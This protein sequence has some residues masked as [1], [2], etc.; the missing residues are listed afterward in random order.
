MLKPS[1]N[2]ILSQILTSVQLT[3]IIV[4][5][6]LIV[7]ILWGPLIAHATLDTQETEQHALVNVITLFSI[8]VPFLSHL[9][10]R[11]QRIN[12]FRFNRNNQI[13]AKKGEHFHPTVLVTM[14]YLV[15]ADFIST[16][17]PRNL[18][19]YTFKICIINKFNGITENQL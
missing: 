12:C 4:M 15:T 7:T 18:R 9:Q 19:E 5:S 6:M 16:K 17:N 14:L 2:A 1:L 10:C 11:K 3:P 8:I 13:W